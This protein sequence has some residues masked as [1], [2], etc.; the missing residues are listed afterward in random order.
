M[1]I[2]DIIRMYASPHSSTTEDGRMLALSLAEIQSELMRLREEMGKS[3]PTPSS[4]IS[5]IDTSAL[6]AAISKLTPLPTQNLDL[7]PVFRS[8]EQTASAIK[9]LLGEVK[10]TNHRITGIGTGYAAPDPRHLIDLK[11]H[12]TDASTQYDYSTRIDALPVYIGRAEQGTP[13]SSLWAIER[14]SYD[15]SNR[16]TCIQVL[17]GS[18]DARAS[19]PWDG[20][21]IIPGGPL[22]TSL[23]L[24][25]STSLTTQG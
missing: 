14:Y 9:E 7:N 16:V 12:I 18:W 5:T 4:V 21:I 10:T 15:G 2:N 8:Y 23:T 20:D 25:T 19:L 11:R 13:N 3:S 6:E 24:E 1:A 22:E 17:F